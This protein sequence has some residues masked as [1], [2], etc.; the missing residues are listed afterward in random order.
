MWMAPLLWTIHSTVL[1]TETQFIILSSLVDHLKERTLPSILFKVPQPRAESLRP[2]ARAHYTKVCS[3]A[4]R[5]DFSSFCRVHAAF[6]ITHRLD[7]GFKKSIEWLHSPGT[8]LWHARPLQ[9]IMLS[10]NNA[11]NLESVAVAHCCQSSCLRTHPYCIIE[12]FKSSFVIEYRKWRTV[13][14]GEY[15]GNHHTKLRIN[16]LIHEELPKA[17]AKVSYWSQSPFALRD[18]GNQF[19]FVAQKSKYSWITCSMTISYLWALYG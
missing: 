16:S 12:F 9:P 8:E 19:Q 13:E 10:S 4:L 6:W 3:C 5:R 11:L 17:A 7:T 14:S 18:Q 15:A 2:E 1:R